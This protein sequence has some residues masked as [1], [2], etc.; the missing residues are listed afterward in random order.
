M[1]AW[2]NIGIIPGLSISSTGLWRA[3]STLAYVVMEVSWMVPGYRSLSRAAAGRTLIT[4]FAIFAGILLSA[5]LY[6]WIMSRLELRRAWKRAF[7]AVALLAWCI[8]ALFM[9]GPSYHSGDLV[10]ILQ[11]FFTSFRGSSAIIPFEYQMLVIVTLLW[12]RGV[13]LAQSWIGMTHVLRSFRLGAGLYLVLGL[14][15]VGH[16]QEEPKLI[17]FLFLISGLVAMASA[18]TASLGLLRGA[19]EPRFKRTWVLSTV[20]ASTIVVG[21]A[22]LFG[23]VAS[24]NLSAPIA[25][26]MRMI[27]GLLLLVLVLFIS[28]LLLVMALILP[29]LLQRLESFFDLQGLAQRITE[30]LQALVYFFQDL[31]RLFQRARAVIPDLAF[32]K[33]YLLWALLLALILLVLRRVGKGWLDLQP[34][35][36]GEDEV[37]ELWGREDLLRQVRA[38]FRRTVQRLVTRLAKLRVSRRLL[39]AA[40]IRRIYAYMMELVA[41][42]DHPRHEAQTPIEYLSTL[43]SLF[44]G[45]ESDVRLITD[46]YN[47]VRYG[48][49]PETHR[50]LV[51]VEDAWRRVRSRGKEMSRNLRKVEQAASEWAESSSNKTVA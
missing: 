34:I 29:G 35:R 27:F 22:A 6:T 49:F 45:Q 43:I 10:G 8:L 20:A 4:L 11:R 28:P 32:L 24:L 51:R 15:N 41:S 40:R 38:G 25:A 13:F 5:N 44:P 37:D 46:A 23:V 36:T 2:R 42:L 7:S 3:T 47:R 33:P 17:V 9:L 19:R 48:Q 12:L 26:F 21:F 14:F 16:W 1:E 18:R 31:M 30:V 39:A 50:E